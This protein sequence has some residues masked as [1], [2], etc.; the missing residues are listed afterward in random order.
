MIRKD[1]KLIFKAII[2]VITKFTLSSVD[3]EAIL[4][5]LKSTLFLKLKL[6][7]SRLVSFFCLKST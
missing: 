3:I 4:S 7:L 5:Q 1:R 6:T 2:F